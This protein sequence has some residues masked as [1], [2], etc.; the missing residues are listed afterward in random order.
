MAESR[1]RYK[2]VNAFSPRWRRA[3]CGCSLAKFSVFQESLFISIVCT[4]V[5]GKGVRFL[6][7]FLLILAPT[8]CYS[9]GT[10]Q[11]S[12]LQF[13]TKNQESIHQI[14]EGYKK[15]SFNWEQLIATF[16]GVILL[17]FLTWKLWF[18][19][20]LKSHIQKKTLEAIDEINNLKTAKILVVSNGD[21]TFL[22]SF[23]KEKKF[24]NVKFVQMP[25]A[26]QPVS[27][28]DYELVFGNNDNNALDKSALRKFVGEDNLLFY[29]GKSGSWDFAN[30]TPE[31]SKKINFANS[32]AQIYGN[33]LS[34]LEFLALVNPKIKNV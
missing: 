32:R 19:D 24:P 27:D 33:L 16:S 3:V 1:M 28:F 12:V 26:Y 13:L 18:Q 9:Q 22:K 14:V 25:S 6:M 8:F 34:S 30:D 5:R 29:F 23:F 15:V 10:A 11:D 17:I 4:F 20:W 31:L 21:D 2:S 7:I